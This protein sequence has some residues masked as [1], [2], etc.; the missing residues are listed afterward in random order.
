M[1]GG[2]AL[3]VWHS[4]TPSHGKN[5][6]LFSGTAL[7]HFYKIRHSDGVQTARDLKGAG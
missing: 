4:P 3:L 5:C 1:G 6:T 2:L 7:T